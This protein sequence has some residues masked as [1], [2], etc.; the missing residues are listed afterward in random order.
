MLLGSSMKFHITF[1]FVLVFSIAY[2]VPII[3]TS[4]TALLHACRL[5]QV[6]A[7]LREFHLYNLLP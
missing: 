7:R 2:D 3:I 1:V 4:S 5:V 6:G